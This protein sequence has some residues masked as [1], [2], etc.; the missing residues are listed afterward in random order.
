MTIR[1]D[2][3]R[4]RNVPV[5][6]QLRYFAQGGWTPASLPNLR[7]WL[8]AQFT[9]DVTVNTTP[10]PDTV[11]AWLDHYTVDGADDVA[12]ST[13]QP[14]WQPTGWNS[15]QPCVKFNSASSTKLGKTSADLATALS[16]NAP[17][18]IYLVGDWSTAEANDFDISF[19]AAGANPVIRFG[20]PTTTSCS[21]TVRDDAGNER[22]VTSSGGAISSRHIVTMVRPADFADAKIYVDG[23]VVSG[24]ASP[25]TLGTTTLT[26]FHL[27]A[28][29]TGGAPFSNIREAAVLVY[30][31]AHSDADRVLVQNYLNARWSG[32]PALP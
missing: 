16:N 5:A 6:R 17:F 4:R 12:E 2:I 29:N 13:N 10:D 25:A 7:L 28:G 19:G 9:S 8:D 27:G 1:R 3:T 31:G 32:L 30:T 18:T 26:R 20:T 11:S 23:V 14:E 22:S 24:A 21:L 15:S